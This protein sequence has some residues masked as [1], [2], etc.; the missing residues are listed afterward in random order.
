MG[1]LD[2]G[3]EH[4][5]DGC[6]TA[7]EQLLPVLAGTAADLANVVATDCAPAFMVPHTAS[8]DATK[9][10]GQC[11]LCLLGVGCE[12]DGRGDGVASLE[13]VHAARRDSVQGVYFAG[14]GYHAGCINWWL[15]RVDSTKPPQATMLTT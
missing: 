3:L 13:A 11:Y 9:A 7:V 5:W 6:K 8:G 1:V 12:G 10:P 15:H 2:A 4:A 14:R